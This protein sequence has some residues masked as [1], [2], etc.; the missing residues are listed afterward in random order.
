ML[1]WSAL[2]A[3][4]ALRFVCVDAAPVHLRFGLG[5]IH[6]RALHGRLEETAWLNLR[7]GARHKQPLI[8]LPEVSDHV[9]EQSQSAVFLPIRFFGRVTFT[10]ASPDF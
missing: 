6:F 2:A 9:V 4:Q 1:A 8:P 5:S 3:C 10:Q 7:Y